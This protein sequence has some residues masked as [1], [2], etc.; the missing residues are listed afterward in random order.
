MQNFVPQL[1]PLQRENVACECIKIH[2]ELV[3]NTLTWY[4]LSY[5]Q[6]TK[7]GARK[8]MD[9]HLRLYICL[10]SNLCTF[11]F[12]ALVW[13]NEKLRPNSHTNFISEVINI[14]FWR[15]WHFDVKGT[16]WVDLEH[17]VILTQ[18]VRRF[19]M[20]VTPLFC[21]KTWA[22][23]KSDVLVKIGPKRYYLLLAKESRLF[24]VDSVCLHLM[25]YIKVP[26]L[27][28]QIK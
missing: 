26:P 15:I 20:S 7:M 23:F 19:D 3:L 4:F 18:S 2:K 27:L 24:L 17:T 10:C 5:L 11:L 1:K 25:A 12:N 14:D 21:L 22:S 16:G 9:E 28:N 13:K 6:F 8:D